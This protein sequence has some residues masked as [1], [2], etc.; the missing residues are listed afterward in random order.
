MISYLADK[1]QIKNIV[2]IIYYQTLIILGHRKVYCGLRHYHVYVLLIKN[3]I[4]DIV[5]ITI[6][7]II[8]FRIVLGL[9]YLFKF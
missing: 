1:E 4:T 8:F 3:I 7:F 9:Y 2:V 6:I 5:L